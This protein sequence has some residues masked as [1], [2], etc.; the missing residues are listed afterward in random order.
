M[1]LMNI[2]LPNAKICKHKRRDKKQRFFYNLMGTLQYIKC[3]CFSVRTLTFLPP[4]LWFA[5]EGGINNP[6]GYWCFFSCWT[7]NLWIPRQISTRFNQWVEKLLC[8][9]KFCQI[10]D[11]TEDPTVL[12]TKR[13][14]LQCELQFFRLEK[15]NTGECHY[16]GKSLIRTWVLLHK[17]EPN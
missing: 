10:S 17:E 11:L 1:K 12:L 7:N 8:S 9:Y 13:E 15:V 6:S 4:L 5:K 2:N 16:F 3:A 14:Q